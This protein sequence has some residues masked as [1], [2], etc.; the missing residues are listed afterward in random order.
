MYIFFSNN[1]YVYFI[2]I[3]IIINLKVYIDEKKHRVVITDI[4]Q[5]E[6]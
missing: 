6:I 4:A 3:I 5:L 2:I 1:I